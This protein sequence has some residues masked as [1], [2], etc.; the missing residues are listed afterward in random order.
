MGPLQDMD[1]LRASLR[2]DAR[3]LTAD[4]DEAEDL[5]QEC[6]LLALRYGETLRH[7]D[8][9]HA[10]C[11][12]VL[13]NLLRQRLRR[14]W[15]R[16]VA[17]AGGSWEDASDPWRQVDTA[18]VVDAALQELPPRLRTAVR[19]FYFGGQSI[20]SIA[21][22]EGRAE[23]TIKRWLHEGRE[24]LRMSLAE[25]VS[26]APLA[27]IYASNWLED[28]RR[29]VLDAVRRAG[30]APALCELMETDALPRDAALI[31]LGEQAGCRTGLELLL[32][33]RGTK[34]IAETPVLLFGPPRETAVLAAWRAGADAY[35]TDPSSPDVA[36]ILAKLRQVPSPAPDP[37]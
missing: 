33:I 35:L 8:R 27:R 31:I 32:A 24:A 21:D 13:R 34:E 1:A 28:A 9:L 12:T 10:W 29:N 26:G 36:A 17:G 25:S 22:G 3:R 15:Y 16:E 20:A 7:P 5:V 19:R 18:L 11:R 6:L 2:R 30:F 14:R 37:R 4:A 23:G